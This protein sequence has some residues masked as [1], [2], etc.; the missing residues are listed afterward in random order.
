MT[1]YKPSK[2]DERAARLAEQLRANLRKRKSQARGVASAAPAS[3]D[4]DTTPQP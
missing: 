4:T 3:N 1:N 2:A